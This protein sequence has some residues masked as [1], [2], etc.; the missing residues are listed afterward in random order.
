VFRLHE[1]Q[2]QLDDAHGSLE[3]LQRQQRVQL[4]GTPHSDE[5]PGSDMPRPQQLPPLLRQR[6]ASR[7]PAADGTADANELRAAR[8]QVSAQARQLTKQVRHGLSH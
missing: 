6:A 1:V 2:L 3:A 7:P 4:Y 5:Q 8:Q